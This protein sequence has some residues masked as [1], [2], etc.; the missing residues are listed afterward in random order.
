[1]IPYF[2][3][4]FITLIKFNQFLHNIKHFYFQFSLK[5]NIHTNNE[6]AFRYAARNGHLNI[7]KY[8]ISLHNTS[9]SG[10]PS[11][12]IRNTH[13]KINI[14]AKD[15]WAFRWAAI[16]NHLNIL[17]FLIS[18][19]NTYGKINIHTYDDWAFRWAAFNGHLN[20]LKYLIS[21]QKTHKKN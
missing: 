9:S 6:E 7:L 16:C 1:M 12:M 15:E 14:H 3:N 17:K 5:I 20:I 19:H 8:L 11:F 13:K 21:L 2:S 4:K 10:L 18:L